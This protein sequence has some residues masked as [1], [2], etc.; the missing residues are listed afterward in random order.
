MSLA[1]EQARVA[2][3]VALVGV[4]LC[5][6]VFG[7][8]VY[9]AV[10]AR[11]SSDVLARRLCTPGWCS[12]WDGWGWTHLLLYFG[13]GL[14]MPDHYLAFG[15]LGVAWEGWEFLLSATRCTKWDF[16]PGQCRPGE[17]PGEWWYAKWTDLVFNMLGYTAGSVL[18]NMLRGRPLLPLGRG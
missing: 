16:I 15:A 2:W 12:P 7:V 4:L 1:V 3:T 9:G 6:V 8:V 17:Q 5:A 13:I 18:G 14:L 10:Y 11:T